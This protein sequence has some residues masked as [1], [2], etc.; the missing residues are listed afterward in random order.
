MPS[1]S[2]LD[3]SDSSFV[4]NTKPINRN[5][6]TLTD[7]TEL[8]KQWQAGDMSARD[9]LLLRYAKFAR[10]R[11]SHRVP[12]VDLDEVQ[13]ALLLRLLNA[14]P[15]FEFR[16]SL[17]SFYK[18]MEQRTLAT[19]YRDR[20][21][22]QPPYDPHTLTLEDVDQT[23]MSRMVSLGEHY[24][25]LAD[26]M[27]KFTQRQYEIFDLALLQDV[28][29]KLVAE[30][31]GISEDTVNETVYKCRKKLRDAAGEHYMKISK[32]GEAQLDA[33]DLDLRRINQALGR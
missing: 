16:C 18:L 9:E 30:E 31:F 32:S 15:T 23:T 12:R 5:R 28:P 10:P 24:G 13:Q 26:G 6:W 22:R 14:L 19:Y 21:R 3:G 1:Q 20:Y 2:I 4:A 29:R 17:Q 8:L 11:L 27:K 7:N 33:L 25:R